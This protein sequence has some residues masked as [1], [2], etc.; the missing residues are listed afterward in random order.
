MKLQFCLEKNTWQFYSVY[1]ICLVCVIVQNQMI[2]QDSQV[3]FDQLNKC[4][5]LS[6]LEIDSPFV[7]ASA[8][9]KIMFLSSAQWK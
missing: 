1:P 5:N 9:Q 6:N 4:F 2:V 8:L 3:L 7:S